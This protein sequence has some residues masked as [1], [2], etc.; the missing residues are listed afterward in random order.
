M[1]TKSRQRCER[2]EDSASDTRHENSHIIAHLAHE[3]RGGRR[4]L[5]LCHCACLDS[6]ERLRQ[7]FRED[8]AADVFA[9]LL[10][11]AAF[12][13]GGRILSTAVGLLVSDSRM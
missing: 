6:H 10:G 5:R 8:C 12:G 3:L 13:V 1:I 11:T 4:S 2:G 9:S 7:R